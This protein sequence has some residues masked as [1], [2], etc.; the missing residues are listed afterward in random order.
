MCGY[1]HEPE[2][3]RILLAGRGEQYD[4]DECSV[5]LC[6]T[7]RAS[8]GPASGEAQEAPEAGEGDLE[9][10][11]DKGEAGGCHRQKPKKK[12]LSAGDIRGHMGSPKARRIGQAHLG[13]VLHEKG[14]EKDEEAPAIKYLGVCFETGW[15]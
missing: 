6:A 4:G 7:A 13:A 15:G 1:K 11:A 14:T 5:T 8:N 12:L 3:E 9:D 2:T 10:P